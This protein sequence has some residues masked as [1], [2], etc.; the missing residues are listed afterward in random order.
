MCNVDIGFKIKKINDSLQKKADKS[1]E[2][3]DLTFSQHHVLVYLIHCENSKTSLK[4]VEKKF[5]VSQATMAGIVKRLEE[6]GMLDSYT[7]ENDKRIK[8]I[9]LTEKGK[10]VCAKSKEMM[11]KS[12]KKIKSLY[13]EEEMNNFINYLDRLYKLLNKENDRLC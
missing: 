2:E 6:K 11:I 3:M 13:S 9:R 8:M 1:M 10:N 4:S 7:L 5:K 12:E